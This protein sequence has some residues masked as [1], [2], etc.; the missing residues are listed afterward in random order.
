LKFSKRRRAVPLRPIWTIMVAAKVDQSRV[1]VTKFRQNRL[2][3]KGRSAGAGQRH[4]D[5]QNH[6]QTRLKILALQVCDRANIEPDRPTASRTGRALW[7]QNVKECKT[8]KPSLGVAPTSSAQWTRR[9]TKKIRRNVHQYSRKRDIF[10][11]CL[12][13]LTCNLDL[14]TWPR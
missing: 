3:M 1:L 5:R 12:W 6:R 10:T 4:T 2:T 9:T 14:R 8:R 11:L 13:P 7:T